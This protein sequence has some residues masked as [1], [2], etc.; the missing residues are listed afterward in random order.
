MREGGLWRQLIN[1][2]FI[3]NY[4][5]LSIVIPAKAGM[6]LWNKMFNIHTHTYLRGIIWKK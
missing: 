1:K 5:F 4:Y 2:I 6:T 3:L